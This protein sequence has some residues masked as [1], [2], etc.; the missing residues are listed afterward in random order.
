VQATLRRP[1]LHPELHSIFAHER[2]QHDHATPITDAE[3]SAS[4]ASE[5][6]AIRSSRA[7]DG[8]TVYAEVVPLLEGGDEELRRAA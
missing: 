7:G 8:A 1:F 6:A 4:I 3:G 5:S 2:L